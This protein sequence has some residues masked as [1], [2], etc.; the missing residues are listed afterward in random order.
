MTIKNIPKEHLPADEQAR[1]FQSVINQSNNAIYIHETGTGGFLYVN[2]QACADL[3]YSRDELLGMKVTDVDAGLPDEATRKGVVVDKL[4]EDGWLFFQSRHRRQDGSEFPVELS[5]KTVVRGGKRFSVTTALDITDR[6]RAE[7][8]LRESEWRYR[9]L[10]DG[11]NDAVFV[12]GIDQSGLPSNFI[13]VNEVACRRLGYTREEFLNMSPLDIGPDGDV[14]A[15][16]RGREL[17]TKGHILFE[18]EHVAKDGRRVP[19]ESNVRVFDFQGR[20]AVLSIARDI[21]DRKQAAEKIIKEKEQA[22]RYLDI[23]G[24]ILVAIDADQGVT[25]INKKGCQVL[26]ADN[27]KEIVGHNWFDTCLPESNREETKEVFS[28]LMAGDVE[29]VEYFENNIITKQGEERLIAWHNTILTDDQGRI[30]G[31]LSSGEDITERR[32]AEQERHRLER[33][34]RHSQKMEAMGTLAGGIAHD[35]N[36]ILAGIMGYTELAMSQAAESSQL[37]ADLEE[38]LKAT[39]RARDLVARI[40]AFSRRK[41]RERGAV[42]IGPIVKEALKLLRAS[43]PTTI[44]I[45]PD[46][47]TGEARVLADPGQIHQVLMNLCANAAKAMEQGGGVLEVTVSE[48]AMDDIRAASHPDLKA[49]PY[50]RLGVK[51]T[52]H[53]IDPEI[54]ERIFDPY[55]TTRATGEGT[56]MGLAVVH[57]IVRS[58]GGAVLVESRPE[59]GSLFEV[60]L[61]RTLD[62]PAEEGD[63]CSSL[64]RGAERILLVDDEQTLVNL[65]TRV[66][67]SLGYEVVAK[68]GSLEALEEFK[69]HP[70]K[71]DLV[72]TDQTMPHLTGIGLAEK[73]LEIR[74]DTPIILCTGFSRQATPGRVAEAGIRAMVQKPMARR[75]IA[76][77]IRRVLA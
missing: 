29:P 40:L 71:F 31:T 45:R 54:V 42:Y 34:L 55:F 75:Q 51:D 44:D 6:K 66:L 10:F 13:E 62:R 74:S 48:E 8:A 20:R 25:L 39:H 22:Q 36:N 27:E 19:V 15:P 63:T 67:E 2:D 5:V 35:F 23:A 68:T 57:G 69:S 21:T 32:R 33:Q 65:G 47:S 11:S 12:H 24:V 26:G 9:L 38:I 41:E 3:G 1:L 46:I 28:K 4:R 53:G 70:E 43:I 72:I 76:E 64:P 59:E 56:G 52:G 50:V 14:D 73:I 49:G 58:L 7:E 60:Y 77:T 37:E 61:P 30:V 16:A 18:G 17:L